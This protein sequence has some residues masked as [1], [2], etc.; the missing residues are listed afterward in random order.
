MVEVVDEENHTVEVVPR[1]VI[2]ANNLLHRTVAILC[3][4]RTGETYV[5]RRTD[6]KDVY[7]GAYDVCVG[8]VV[9]AGETY[10]QTARRELAEE[11]GIEGAE[12]LFLFIHKYVGPRKRCLIGAYKLEW[13]GSIHHQETEVAWGAWV[14]PDELEHMLGEEEFMPDHLDVYRRILMGEN[15]SE[16]S[17]SEEGPGV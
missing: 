16:Q 17:G 14:A 11:L 9:A 8:G 15:A 10:E 2:R 4:N 7:P 13:N 1:N 12:P 6:T 5:H 3:R